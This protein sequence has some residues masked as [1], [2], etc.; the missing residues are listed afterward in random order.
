M[1]KSGRMLWAE[2]R[3]LERSGDRHCLEKSLDGP[4]D[5][6]DRPVWVRCRNFDAVH[7]RRHGK[8]EHQNG[9]GLRPRGLVL[10]IE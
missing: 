4:D 6:V 3:G 5:E 2:E 7:A 10:E 1:E 9:A 8:A